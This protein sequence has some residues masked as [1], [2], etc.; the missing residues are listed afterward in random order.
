[1]RSTGIMPNFQANQPKTGIH[2]SSRFSTMAGSSSSGNSAKVSHTDWCLP[3]TSAA[4][5]GRCSRPRT[6]TRVP[7]IAS[8]HHCEALAQTF[9]AAMDQA[10]G[11][12]RKPK[13]S[14]RKATRLT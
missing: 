4:P 11:V 1:V 8:S 5:A 7:A 14:T 6:S 2:M 3:A 10:R 13:P 9:S 12:A